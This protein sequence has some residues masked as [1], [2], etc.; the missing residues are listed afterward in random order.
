M[1][2]RTF[3]KRIAKV[4]LALP[5]VSGARWVR[6]EETAVKPNII[7]I[8]A[9]D[10]GI[11]DFGCYGGEIINTPFIDQLAKEGMKFTNHYSGSTVCAPSRSCL[12]T[13]Q[14]TGHTL[15]RGNRT[16]TGNKNLPLRLEDRTVEEI[17]QN[18]GYKTACIGKW[19]LGLNDSTG[20]PNQKGFDFF[21][22]YVDQKR[23]HRYYPEYVWKNDE[24]VLFPDNPT[25]RTDYIHDH[26][27]QEALRFIKDNKDNPFFLYL[28]YTIP[29]VDLDVPED[30]MQ[31]YYEKFGNEQPFPGDEQYRAHPTPHAAYAGM[32]SRMDRDIGSI[33]KLIQSLELDQDTL[34]MFSSDN[35]ATDAGGADPAFFDSNG[36]FRGNKRDFYEGGIRAPFIARWTGK[37]Q[38]GTTTDHI[39]AFWDIL[40]TFAEIAGQSVPEN[41]DGISIMPTLLGDSERQAKHEYLYWEIDIKKGRQ[42][43]RKGD[44]KGLRYNVKDNPNMKLELYNLKDDPSE[45]ENMAD[46]NPEIVEELQQLMKSARTDSEHFGGDYFNNFPTKVEHIDEKSKTFLLKQN[47]PNPFNATTRISYT[48]PDD[49]H[50]QLEI[51]NILGIKVRTLVNGYQRENLYSVTWNGLSDWGHKVGSGKY[52]YQLKATCDNKVFMDNKRMLFIK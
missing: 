3:C 4:G 51:Y 39:S 18:A 14:H 24:K 7:Y 43:I 10:A 30:S 32:I 28:P 22:G 52:I 19:G 15:I 37:I 42:A 50:V 47:Y 49:A 2:R 27:T 13:G 46:E 26:F 48:L 9:D 6:S 1:N 38:P 17:L 20:A 5:L 8:L 36:I 35:G 33:V 12:M 29:H 40:P 21:Y 31:P 41:I 44:W 11:G 34:I 45:S 23:A 25:E 16:T